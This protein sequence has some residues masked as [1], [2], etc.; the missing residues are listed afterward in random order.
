MSGV[1]RDR[2]GDGA[3]EARFTLDG[4]DKEVHWS[5]ERS[6]ISKTDLFVPVWP[7]GCALVGRGDR[8][9]RAS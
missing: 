9:G 2:L 3:P 8:S 5:G 6:Q 1:D 4:W 7:L